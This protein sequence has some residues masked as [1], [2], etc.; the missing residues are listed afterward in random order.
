MSND[1]NIADVLA[2]VY[3]HG[4]LLRVVCVCESKSEN[5]AHSSLKTLP[6]KLYAQRVFP[7][8][9]IVLAVLIACF[10]PST[11]AHAAETT[12]PNGI[13]LFDIVSAGDFFEVSAGYRTGGRTNMAAAIGDELSSGPAAR[14]LTL[15]VYGC[16]G[17]IDFFNNND[18]TGFQLRV[19]A[20]GQPLVTEH[21]GIYLREMP[22]GRELPE[23]VNSDRKFR[24][25]VEKEVRLALL[26]ADQVLADPQE[27]FNKEYGTDR[28]F[29]GMSGGVPENIAQE[30]GSIPVR[31]S[32][33]R[34]TP[35]SPML[36]AERTLKFV[37]DFPVGAVVFA[38]PVPGVYYDA[39]YSMLVLDRL[40]RR[41]VPG[42]PTTT[43]PLNVEPYYYRLELPGPAGQFPEQVQETLL[44]EI[45]RLSLS[46]SRPE[47]LEAARREA[48][49]Y[50]NSGEARQWFASQGISLRRDEGLRSVQSFSADDLRTTARDMLITNRV[51]ASWAPKI[52]GTTIEVEKLSSSSS[53]GDSTSPTNSTNPS[54]NL[55]P[56]RVMPFPQHAHNQ[57]LFGLAERLPS[58]VWIVPSTI[59]A[60]F[61]AGGPLTRFEQEPAAET[62]RQFQIYR[63]GRILVLSPA[64]SIDKARRL[65]SGFVG[66]PSDSSPTVLRGDVAVSALPALFV[67]KTVLDRKLIETGLWH[68][69]TLRLDAGLGS[70]MLVSDP[71]VL[72]WIR[73]ISSEQLSET[74]LAWARE[75][76]EHH[77]P[78][79]LP[80]LQA[81]TWEREPQS[82]VMDVGT[83][84]AA[85]VQ[86]IAKTYF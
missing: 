63:S 14:A 33:T 49:E 4:M 75:A 57:R 11:L 21:V 62:V 39:W 61:I 43:L 59:N 50:L 42:R 67:L 28:M 84:S 66:N 2:F 56:I 47:D 29:V 9:C 85:D 32:A 18:R 44:Q 3:V 10:A 41:A 34:Q 76:A 38:V 60:V 22:S 17:Q 12:L 13:H 23:P 65:W 72:E 37:S 26:G 15:A 35:K 86:A 16:G 51:L 53:A 20:W 71:R 78:D 48:T 30:L 58:G 81:L 69:V 25:Q 46:R 27:F 1:A 5:L 31:R 70:T 8:T 19:P 68:E 54:G 52:R 80:D 73:R 74:D 64:A 82:L 77:L 40:I 55:Q 83:V 79:V 6:S 24:D 45:E 7:R 36:T